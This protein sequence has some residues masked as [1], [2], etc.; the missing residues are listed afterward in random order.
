MTDKTKGYL[1]LRQVVLSC[2]NERDA[3]TKSDYKRMLQFAIEGFRKFSLFHIPCIRHCW[4]T[5]DS[6]LYSVSFPD[7]LV[8]FMSVGIPIEGRYWEFTKTRN[9]IIPQ[10][11]EINESRQEADQR[12]IR[13]VETYGMSP[14][15]QYL[16][17]ED[18]PNRRIIIHGPP[19]SEVLVYYKSTGI[20]TDGDTVIP[21]H[22]FEALKA[23]VHY[24]L[25]M[26]S[27]DSANKT[28]LLRRTYLGEVK[29]MR[30]FENSFTV[31]ELDRKSVV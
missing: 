23:Y 20:N 30:D 11:E 14:Y 22:A 5:V 12:S 18:L 6:K 10:C 27:N 3:Y 28:E 4:I 16:F 29:D 1:T 9:R 15:N 8:K 26:F 25:S 17:S 24:K 13:P 2:E 21:V 19:I 7:D 31:A